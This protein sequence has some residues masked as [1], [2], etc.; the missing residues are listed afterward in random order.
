[1]MTLSLSFFF[2]L[3]LGPCVRERPFWTFL[4]LGDF[5]LWDFFLVIVGTG[6]ESFASPSSRFS[7]W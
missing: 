5:V 7:F 3:F 2:L 1:M 6:V 4:F